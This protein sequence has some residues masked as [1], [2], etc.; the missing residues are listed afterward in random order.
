M[1]YISDYDVLSS[2]MQDAKSYS[3]ENEKSF[4]N[5]LI[6]YWNSLLMNGKTD[7]LR[8]SVY[9]WK[10]QFDRHFQEEQTVAKDIAYMIFDTLQ[11]SEL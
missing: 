1:P 4:W 2:V 10:I 9:N 3:K 8:S 11:N 5:D 7:E 6:N